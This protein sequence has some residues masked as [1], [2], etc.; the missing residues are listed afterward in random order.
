MCICQTWTT[1]D[2]TWAS[3][4]GFSRR[5]DATGATGTPISDVLRRVVGFSG[6]PRIKDH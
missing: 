6:V 1:K 2:P 5:L 4:D 3:L